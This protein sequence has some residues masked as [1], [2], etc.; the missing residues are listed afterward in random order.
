MPVPRPRLEGQPRPGRE[1]DSAVSW[2]RGSGRTEA[3]GGAAPAPAGGWGRAGRGAGPAALS[4]Q[5]QEVG[6]PAGQQQRPDEHR[7]AEEHEGQQLPQQLQHVDGGRGRHRAVP[8]ARGPVGQG[9][10]G[11][12]EQAQRTVPSRA[13]PPSDTEPGPVGGSADT[14]T[15]LGPGPQKSKHT[16]S[17][18]R[19]PKVLIFS[20]TTIWMLSLRLHYR[21]LLNQVPFI[22]QLLT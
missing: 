10:R 19:K 18:L 16:F 7:V 12:P 1:A 14:G 21:I 6:G 9:R 20:M 22:L 3:G 13:Q 2:P 15:R 5:H 17:R 11:D 4:L 8:E